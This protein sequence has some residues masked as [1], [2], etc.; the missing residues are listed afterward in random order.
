MRRF[1]LPYALTLLFSVTPGWVCCL[2]ILPLRVDFGWFSGEHPDYSPS[3][4]SSGV[5]L[6]AGS[7]ACEPLIGI[8]NGSVISRITVAVVYISLLVSVIV[9]VGNAAFTS[10]SRL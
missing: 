8:G 9:T 7:Q 4:R 2:I 3:L 6:Q 10:S 5:P 1:L